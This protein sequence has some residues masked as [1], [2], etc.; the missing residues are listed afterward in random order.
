ME[1]EKHAKD[2]TKKVPSESIY[3]SW[4]VNDN[5]Y[6]LEFLNLILWFQFSPHPHG[7]RYCKTCIWI[8]MIG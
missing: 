4:N 1:G 7:S 3:K 8:I 5:Y 2:L 6:C